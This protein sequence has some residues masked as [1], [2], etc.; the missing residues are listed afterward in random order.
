MTLAAPASTPPRVATTRHYL[1][2][3][4]DHFAVEHALN[5]WMD[6]SRPVDRDRATA[7]WEQLRATHTRLGHLVETVEPVA[8]LPDMVFTANAA[9][10]VGGVVL[11]ARFATP[12][13]AP[14]AAHARR[15]FTARGHAV[16]T[17]TAV[18][19]AEG[20]L[21]WT[22]RVLLAGTGFR[23]H[24]AAHAEAARVLGVPVV[25]L[26]LVDP[27]Y[28]HLDTALAVLDETTVAWYPPAFDAASRAV[29]EQ[30]FPGSVV[31]DA[32]DAAC[33]GLNAVSDG[34]H[35]VLPVQA[36]GLAAQLA[37]RGYEPVG[38]DTSELA[39]AGGGPK[40][41]TMELRGLRRDG[42]LRGLRRDGE[43]RAGPG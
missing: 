23:T 43:L 33:L 29:V 39:R 30:L 14:E 20:D 22:G 31:A 2:C 38:V 26:R 9:T 41:A 6:P 32:A 36:R 13:R 12:Q 25:P 8:G 4:P 10:V 17:P 24:P 27:R 40:C 28:Y 1:M 34:R 42:E 15:W 5:P 11:G 3:R 37:A 18:N 16:V 35:V 19:E 21:A 7:Q